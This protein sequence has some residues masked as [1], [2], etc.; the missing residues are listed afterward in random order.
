[1]YLVAT[2][3]CVCR[4]AAA[5]LDCN[6]SISIDDSYTKAYHR[7]GSARAAL[8]KYPEAKQ[9]FEKVLKFDPKSKVAM[10]EI[11]KIE[12]VSFSCKNYL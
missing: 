3:F 2:I 8:K 5:E 4:Y 7:R 12:R 9:D 6:M 10:Q 1:M 11:E